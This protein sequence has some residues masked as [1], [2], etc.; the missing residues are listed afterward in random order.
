[1]GSAD[2]AE[3]LQLNKDLA[4]SKPIAH[5]ADVSLILRKMLS[6]SG[7]RQVLS[8]RVLLDMAVFINL[9]VE[10]CARIHGVSST[11]RYPNQY[12]RWKNLKIYVFKHEETAEITIAG[13]IKLSNIKG[14]KDEPDKWK[15][16][17]LILMPSSLWLEDSLRLLIFAALIDGHIP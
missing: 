12:L 10:C 3:K 4:I 17:P 9:I 11:E 8:M 15:E 16:I 7:L 6:P 1:M 14:L 5:R 2:L 13:L